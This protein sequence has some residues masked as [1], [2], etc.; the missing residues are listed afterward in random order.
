MIY[1]LL[2]IGLGMLAINQTMKY[3]YNNQ[4]GQNPCGLCF[5]QNPSLRPNYSIEPQP[6]F[7]DYNFSQIRLQN[8]SIS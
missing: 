8:L 2:V 5:S 6:A 1:I 7:K 3:F 4:L